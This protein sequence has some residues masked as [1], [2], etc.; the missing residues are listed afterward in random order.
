MKKNNYDFQ[1]S[2]F[3]AF[4][5]RV[6][7]IKK[8]K[9]DLEDFKYFITLS[10]YSI[11]SNYSSIARGSAKNELGGSIV[12]SLS[13]PLRELAGT[14]VNNIKINDTYQ[15]SKISSFTSQPNAK[16]FFATRESKIDMSNIKIIPP[17]RNSLNKQPDYIF[18]SDRFKSNNKNYPAD[19]K[20][21][22]T[23]NIEENRL[24]I[25]PH[26]Y[27]RRYEEA[28]LPGFST[29]ISGIK[30]NPLYKNSSETIENIRRSYG[31]TGNTISTT[32]LP[33][34]K[35][36]TPLAVSSY[37][38]G[39]Y[40]RS[41]VT[42]KPENNLPRSLNNDYKNTSLIQ[43]YQFGNYSSKLNHLDKEV[44][45]LRPS[46]NF[47]Q[48][49][50]GKQATSISP[51]RS[52]VSFDKLDTKS[53]PYISPNIPPKYEYTRPHYRNVSRSPIQS[54]LSYSQNEQGFSLNPKSIISTDS[55]NNYPQD[56][57]SQINQKDGYSSR[58]EGYRSNLTP[59][60]STQAIRPS[61]SYLSNNYQEPLQKGYVMNT[62]PQ[63]TQIRDETRG[64][65]ERK[66]G[67]Q[68]YELPS[69]YEGIR[70]STVLETFQNDI[71][72]S[73]IHIKEY[74]PRGFKQEQ[75]GQEAFKYINSEAD[76]SRK[77]EGDQPSASLY[78]FANSKYEQLWNIGSD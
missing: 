78:R 34:G 71:T 73:P 44:S 21:I 53:Q 27:E 6:D 69:S 20:K 54:R 36:Q 4:K 18:S 46:D 13:S 57:R 64:N 76:F 49:Q 7:I 43:P 56:Y 1:I 33:V 52:Q 10:N 48:S 58:F 47:P 25:S 70:R 22:Q 45:S 14:G 67:S 37:L 16:P 8:G 24:K 62:E 15:P 29:R 74:E 77:T 51:I 66:I 2:D 38:D 50:Y 72:T 68:P 17:E 35:P 59:Y 31:I 11:S 63:E 39:N 3:E 60:Q 75:N 42:N 65:E 26:S 61:I 23:E 9:I 40:I 19:F 5:R 41:S 28:G 30:E 12:E 55:N 32:R